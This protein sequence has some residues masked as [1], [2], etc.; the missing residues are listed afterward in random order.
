[1]N[2]QTLA[3]EMA[4]AY[5][6]QETLREERQQVRQHEEEYKRL[7]NLIVSSKVRQSGKYEVVD[8]EVQR[9]RQII[10]DRFRARWPELFNRLATVTM[11]AALEEIEENDLDDVCEIKTVAKP[12]IAL[13]NR[14]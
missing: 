10:S 1:L 14:P 8:K 12:V 5:K 13:R 9:K 7:M 2:Q 11:K 6:L 4:K 3:D